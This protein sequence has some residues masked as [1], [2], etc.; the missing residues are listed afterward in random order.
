VVDYAMQTYNLFDEIHRRSSPFVAMK[1]G[2]HRAQLEIAQAHGLFHHTERTR[3]YRTRLG[4]H[5]PNSMHIMI[6]MS[7]P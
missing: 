6:C 2:L 4:K 5:A 3:H 7:K 1:S